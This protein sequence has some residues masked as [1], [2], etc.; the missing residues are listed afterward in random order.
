MSK[1]IVT[2]LSPDFDAIPAIWV[3]KKFDSSFADAKVEFVPAGTTLDNQPV[4]SDP[5]IIH[6]DTGGGPFDHHA[7]NSYT[8]AAKLVWEWLKKERGIEDVAVDRLMNLIV[9]FDHAKDLSWPDAADDKYELMLPALIAGWKMTY[10]GQY[11]KITELGLIAMDAAYAVMRSKV[12][13]E[14][15]LEQ[16]IEFQ[17]PWGKAIGVEAAN[18]GTLQ[19]GEKLGYAL[20]CKK[21][22]RRGSVRIYGRS[23]FGVDLEKAY[24]KVKKMDPE[25]GW[26]LHASKCLLI[27]GSAKNPT[28]KPTK[29]TLEEVIE[30]LKNA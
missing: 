15:A 16:G 19:V 20:V 21:D 18:E 13:A 14:K 6:V 25:A 29:L 3:L 30:V 8:C 5:N 23:D 12:A 22:P 11:Q 4:S 2:H 1:I 17:S 7:D 27:N 10:G 26:F 9:A 24:Q 28:M